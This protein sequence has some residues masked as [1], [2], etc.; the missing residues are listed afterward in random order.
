MQA[1]VWLGSVAAPTPNLMSFLNYSL[2]NCRVLG[3]PKY[4]MLCVWCSTRTLVRCFYFN[5]SGL[6]LKFPTLVQCG[7]GLLTAVVTVPVTASQ[8]DGLTYSKV[9][10]ILLLRMPSVNTARDSDPHERGIKVVSGGCTRVLAPRQFPDANAAAGGRPQ[11]AR[12]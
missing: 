1:D 2:L 3:F 12:Y 9:R 5:S 10:T 6:D 4:F 8:T 11:N 7:V